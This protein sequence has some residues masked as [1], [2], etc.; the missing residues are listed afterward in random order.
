MNFE[1]QEAFNKII[2]GRN[3]FLSGGAG[4][5]KSYTLEKIR[6]WGHNV[7]KKIAITATTGNAAVLIGG[8]TV[9]SYF[10]L[11]LAKKPPE[12]LF[13]DIK[14]K[15][16]NVLK[17]TQKLEIL[18]IDEVSMMDAEFMIKLSEVLQYIRC[19]DR[20]FGGLQV[21]L[22]GDMAQLRPV[23]GDYCFKSPVWQ[24]MDFDIIDLKVNMRQAN[25]VE[26]ISMLEQLRW[27]RTTPK[28]RNQLRRLKHTVF[29]DDGI[30]P[31]I[32]FC[33]N[34][35]VDAIN[36]SEYSKLLE[37][38]PSRKVFKTVYSNILAKT[39]AK[40]Q[41]IPEEVDL[42]V[43]TQVIITWNIDVENGISNGSR[44]IITA[45]NFN[46]VDVK[47]V[48]GKTINVCYVTSKDDENPD[49]TIAFMPLKYSWAMSSHKSQGSSVDRLVICFEDLWE[50]GQAYVMLSRARSLEC[51]KIIGKLDSSVF[52]CANEVIE[53]YN[54][55]V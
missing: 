46:S 43:G 11:N 54:K 4:V 45:I 32:L 2:N 8:R 31:T 14:Q 34:A 28:I 38:R 1:Q 24:Q 50:A 22:C 33:T 18:V 47:L 51:V 42:C 9:H 52:K 6:E 41:K 26:F 21:I 12:L 13:L 44:G 35:N 36:S 16:K 25:D 7:N 3:I 37:N 23:Q 20:P 53:F 27:G 5:G 29:P 10:G 49:T 48:N 40:S 55:C 19:N 17:K 30:I 39:I 15:Y